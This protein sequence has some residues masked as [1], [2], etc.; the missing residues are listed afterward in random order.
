VRV[1]GLIRIFSLAVLALSIQALPQSHSF[2]MN[3]QY[4]ARLDVTS[5]EDLKKLLGE[6]FKKG[7]VHPSGVLNCVQLLA[8][9]RN[10]REASGQDFQAAQSL[11]AQ[12]VVLQEL[13]L[14]VPAKTSSLHDLSWDDHVLPLL[15]P[16]LAITVSRESTND[17]A[18][19]ADAGRNWRDFD[20]S[21]A[22]SISSKGPDEIVVTGDGFTERL[23]LWG[24]GDFTKDGVESLLVQ[25]FDTLTEGTY[26]NTRLFLLT[27]SSKN[28]QLTVSR[29]IQ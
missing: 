9:Q 25:S 26:R 11:R 19:A 2:E 13:E 15:P 18:K 4:N 16:Q 1:R 24:R 23:V 6:P 17:A 29:S 5:A 14:A 3:V 22:A 21:I 27:R 28:E 20:P 12:C 10:T 8:R 7:V